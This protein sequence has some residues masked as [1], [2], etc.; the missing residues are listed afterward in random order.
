M[1]GPLNVKIDSTGRNFVGGDCVVGIA[2]S[3]GLNGPGIKS[4]WESRFSAPVQTGPGDPP[5]LLYNEY[6]VIPGG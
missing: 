4:R 6:R 1:H 5:G 2:T 3:Y